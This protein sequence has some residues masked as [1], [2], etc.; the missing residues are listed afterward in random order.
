[1]WIPDTWS[2]WLPL[3]CGP[4][5][6]LVSRPLPEVCRCRI[7]LHLAFRI[8][9][10][11]GSGF[12]L[13]GNLTSGVNSTLNQ[14]AL[15]IEVRHL[16][17]IQICCWPVLR[18]PLSRMLVLHLPLVCRDHWLLSLREERTLLVSSGILIPHLL[19]EL[20][21]LR[22]G[23]SP[24]R[25]ALLNDRLSLIRLP[26]AELVILIDSPHG[27]VLALIGA[28]R[29]HPYGMAW[30]KDR[31]RGNSRPLSLLSVPLSHLAFPLFAGRLFPGF[32]QMCSL[33]LRGGRGIRW[34]FGQ[35]VVSQA[36]LR[37]AIGDDLAKSCLSLLLS[38]EL[39]QPAEGLGIIPLISGE[40]CEV[41]SS[42]HVAGSVFQSTFEIAFG[43]GIF[44][45]K[46]IGIAHIAQ[47]IRVSW[48]GAERGQVV[49][50]SLF[51][52]LCLIADPCQHVVRVTVLRSDVECLTKANLCVCQPSLSQLLVAA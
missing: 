40:C 51:V 27:L 11:V 35:R 25:L 10:Q 50:F 46:E 38:A 30:I 28:S 17:R 37:G 16:V 5:E 45:L 21:D 48:I 20:H 24:S 39:T 44:A 42:H 26:S 23:I 7:Q 29:V 8:A 19:G 12:P 52:L 49:P 43:V 32:P 9:V 13:A 18:L 47:Q 4:C 31:L 22:A 3:E 33:A 1:M 6:L 41:A 14:L 36:E 15:V 2:L 34:E